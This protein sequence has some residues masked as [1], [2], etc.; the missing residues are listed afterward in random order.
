MKY[1]SEA[2]FIIKSYISLTYIIS[3]EGIGA[4]VT[5]GK[6]ENLHFR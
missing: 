5:L 1:E 2:N 6:P 4:E 3:N